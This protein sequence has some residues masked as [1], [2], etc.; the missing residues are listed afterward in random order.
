M[1]K[2][3]LIKE[4]ENLNKHNV[5][6]KSFTGIEAGV[7]IKDVLALVKQLDEP[8]KV[9][10][11]K[12]V[13][14]WLESKSEY[15]GVFGIL[16]DF[17][18]RWRNVDDFAI[19]YAENYCDGVGD[20]IDN[21]ARAYLDGYEV[22]KEKLYT[23]VLPNPKCTTSRHKSFLRRTDKGN[24]VLVHGGF[25]REDNTKLTEEEIKSLDE[26]YMAFAQEVAE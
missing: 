19:S 12:D 9:V 16:E 2:Q 26:R 18:D 7:E 8:Q 1:N 10:L 6:H 3:E 25:T 13:A 23:V 15:L 17:V 20:A 14:E 24:I 22:E 11:P 4:I 21:I 5:T